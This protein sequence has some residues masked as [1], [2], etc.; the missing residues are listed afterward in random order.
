[1]RACRAPGRLALLIAWGTLLPF[2]LVQA[3]GDEALATRLNNQGVEA[4]RQGRWEEGVDLVRRAVTANPDDGTARKN[5]S[6]MLLDWSFALERSGDLARA[7]SVLLEAVA[8]DPKLGAAYVRLGDLAF[9]RRSAF[10]DAIRYWKQA[11]GNVSPSEWRAVADRISQAQRDAVIERDFVSQATEHFD[12]RM[13]RDGTTDLDALAGQ[14]EATYAALATQLGGG[15]PMIP[16]IVYAERDIRRTYNQRDWALGFYDGRLRLLGRE[17]AAGGS[18]WLLAH[19]LAHAFLH[20]AYPS[21]SLIWVH[22]GFAQLQENRPVS[23]DERELERAVAGGGAWVPLK[24]LDRRFTHP[25]RRDDVVHAYVQARL[26]VE[27]L[28]T[29]HGIEKFQAFLRELAQGAE[30]GAAF[31]KTFAPDRWAGTDN[32]SWLEVPQAGGGR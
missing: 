21:I 6:G 13:A 26:V 1:M 3:A 19:E 9:F 12:I 25:S 31:D 8:H 5:L 23:D 16:V 28:I 15:P 22:E 32:S 14:L 4:A 11:G 20:H 27:A 10:S 29:R 18:G 24:W 30:A 7:E 17:L 2:S